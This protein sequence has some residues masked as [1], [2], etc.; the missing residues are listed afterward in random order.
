MLFK[1]NFVCTDTNEPAPEAA[2]NIYADCPL[3]AR[4]I[5]LYTAECDY[6]DEYSLSGIELISDCDDLPF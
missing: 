3:D 2:L 1:A 5:A 4:R 6:G